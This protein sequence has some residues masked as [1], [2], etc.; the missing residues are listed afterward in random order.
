MSPFT[1]IIKKNPG[2][3]LGRTGAKGLWIGLNNNVVLHFTG[4]AQVMR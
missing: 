4:R 3:D 2:S 1:H